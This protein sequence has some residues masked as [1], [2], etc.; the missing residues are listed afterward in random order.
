MSQSITLANVMSVRDI[1]NLIGD[2]PLR[3]QYKVLQRSIE[4]T[5]DSS[6]VAIQEQN[7]RVAIEELSRLALLEDYQ[8]RVERVY[9]KQGIYA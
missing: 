9:T 7:N 1:T 3:V 5:I 4:E 8:M 6:E 2:L